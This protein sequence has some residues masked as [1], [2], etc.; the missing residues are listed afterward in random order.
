MPSWSR[1]HGRRTSRGSGT[2]TH[3]AGI[4]AWRDGLI[5]YKTWPPLGASALGGGFFCVRDNFVGPDKF[6][7]RRLDTRLLAARKSSRW[8]TV[9]V[10]RGDI[11][12]PSGKAARWRFRVP[13]ASLIAEIAGFMGLVGRIPAGT[14]LAC[15][16]RRTKRVS[17]VLGLMAKRQVNWLHN[18]LTSPIVPNMALPCTRQRRS[19][20]RALRLACRSGAP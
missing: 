13:S 6:A 1:A 3:A 15:T 19:A 7:G 17:V 18:L 2:G 5:G 12:P 14:G 10:I 9:P 8:T 16:T 11:H 4:G 20:R